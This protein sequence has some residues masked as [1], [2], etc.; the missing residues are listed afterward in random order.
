MQ[1]NTTET[2]IFNQVKADNK[3]AFNT[4]FETYYLELCEFSFHIVGNKELAEEIVADVFANIW[5]KRKSITI[6]TSLKAFLFKST[7]NM[8]IS[9]MR[10]TKKDIVPL[11]DVLAFQA[12][13]NPE[14]DV[15]LIHQEAVD[16][17]ERL[18]SK[19]PNKS[20]IVFK[21]H[22]FDNLK[23]REIAEVL[24][25][26]QKTVEKHMGKALSI[27]RNYTVETLTGLIIL[28]FFLNPILS[29]F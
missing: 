6:N 19:I 11:D 29:I 4:L 15:K 8:T 25:I 7:K 22:R 23:Y 16:S 20:R 3:L 18:L 24:E 2:S 28:G 13:P 21:M 26:S 10:K 27:L 1:G 12:N 9:Y 14:P 5:L 17:V